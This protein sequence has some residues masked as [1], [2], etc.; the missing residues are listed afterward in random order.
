MT[1]LVFSDLQC[2]QFIHFLEHWIFWN[3]NGKAI[4]SVLVWGCRLLCFFLSRARLIIESNDRVPFFNDLA[5]NVTICW[6][7]TSKRGVILFIRNIPAEPNKRIWWRTRLTF[8][9]RKGG[10]VYGA[11]KRHEK[12]TQCTNVG[13]GRLAKRTGGEVKRTVSWAAIG[14]SDRSD[15]WTVCDVGCVTVGG[16]LKGG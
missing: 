12:N 6:F 2:L 11:R 5:P 8:A 10:E 13:R 4:R 15:Y 16:F 9:E 1:V 7:L 14:Y 3:I